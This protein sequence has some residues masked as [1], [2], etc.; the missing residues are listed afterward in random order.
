MAAATIAAIAGAAIGAG[1][2][3]YSITSS[4]QQARL[5]SQAQDQTNQA[6]QRAQAQATAQQKASDETQQRNID[7]ANERSRA[8]AAIAGSTTGSGANASQAGGTLL[9]F[10]GSQAPTVASTPATVTRGQNTLLGS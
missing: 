10:P 5:A 1:G 9:S 3:A 6:A 8:G 2:L 7:L 4:Q